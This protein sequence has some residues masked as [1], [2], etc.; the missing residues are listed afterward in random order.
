[1]SNKAHRRPQPQMRTVV[2]PVHKTTVKTGS[3]LPRI[4]RPESIWWGARF[5]CPCGRSF[6]TMLSYC[7]HYAWDHVYKGKMQ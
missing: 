1:M 7:R 4:P 3:L 6:W 2:R 5:R